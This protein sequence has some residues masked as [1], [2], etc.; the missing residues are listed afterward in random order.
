M[1]AGIVALRGHR[2]TLLERMPQVGRKFLMA[3]RGGLNLTHSEPMDALL[4]RYQGGLWLEHALRAF[5]PE[6]LRL[7]AADLGQKTFIGS[8]RRV[9]PEAMK[10]SPLL[11]AWLARLREL[12]VTILT[13]HDVISLSADR[14]L[15]CRAPDGGILECAADVIILA[16]GGASWPRLGANGNF[17]TLLQHHAIDMAPLEAAN[18]GI[19]IAWSSLFQSRFAG[20]V[21]KNITLKA[22]DETRRGEV[23]ITGEG[24]EGGPVYA[25][26][27]MLRA[28]LRHGG[29][30]PLIIDLRPDLS[31]DQLTARLARQGPKASLATVLRKAGFE[32]AA[33]ALLRESAGEL[34]AMPAPALAA[35]AKHLPLSV[36][37]TSGLEKAISTAGGVKASAFN[38][39]LMLAALP[40]VFVAGEMLDWDAPTGGYLLQACFATGFVAGNAAARWL[41]SPEAADEA[42]DHFGPKMPAPP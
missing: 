22:G 36:I 7:F 32:P 33:Q 30:C 9:F 4:G 41:A 38:D 21:L 13:R 6:A 27:P 25:L 15:R 19:K 28:G 11:R 5:P 37:A 34:A 24:L 8:S 1:A 35:L 2:V 12:G 17:E 23:V 18:C 14:L 26:G 20:H 16:M 3:G 10:S 42:R 40:G 39:D 29:P 31:Q